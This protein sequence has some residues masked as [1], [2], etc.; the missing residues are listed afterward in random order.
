MACFP[1][2]FTSRRLA[3]CLNERKEV[4]AARTKGDPYDSRADN[5]LGL[6]CIHNGF[7][8]RIYRLLLAEATAAAD[9]H[10][11]LERSHISTTHAYEKIDKSINLN[12]YSFIT[13][14]R[15]IGKSYEL[16]SFRLAQLL[17]GATNP[18]VPQQDLVRYVRRRHGDK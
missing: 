1:D 14:T 18:E 7:S 9:D 17:V 6:W 13:R 15:Q 3:Y 11:E 8:R 10:P 5:G 12:N 4:R 16:F 2:G